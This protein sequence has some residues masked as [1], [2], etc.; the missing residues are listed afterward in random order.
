MEILQFW[1]QL[2]LR[3]VHN[4]RV[5]M[6]YTLQHEP[7]FLVDLVLVSLPWVPPPLLPPEAFFLRSSFLS[8]SSSTSLTL[9]FFLSSSSPPARWPDS[10][11]I[12]PAPL[13]KSFSALAVINGSKVFTQLSMSA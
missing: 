2:G 13:C 5:E 7:F 1:K 12:L 8:T 10:S 6:D 9:P 11:N 3:A 4:E